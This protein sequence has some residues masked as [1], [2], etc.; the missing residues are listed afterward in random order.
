MFRSL[1]P[2]F[3]RLLRADLGPVLRLIHSIPRFERDCPWRRSRAREPDGLDAHAASCPPPSWRHWNL[4][5]RA[6]L[7]SPRPDKPSRDATWTIGWTGLR[8]P[9]ASPV[10]AIRCSAPADSS[11]PVRRVRGY[12]PNP[13]HAVVEHGSPARPTGATSPTTVTSTSRSF[14]G[15]YH[16]RPATFSRQSPADGSLGN[17]R[18][19]PAFLRCYRSALHSRDASSNP[20][21]AANRRRP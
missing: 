4:M 2:P 9:R 16:R 1:N 19:D 17:R 13:M 14:R 18:R 5:P 11:N 12:A 7:P 21:D 6:Q 8:R 3:S 15:H 10:S 20:D